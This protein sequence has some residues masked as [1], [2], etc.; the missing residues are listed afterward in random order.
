MTSLAA[1]DIKAIFIQLMETM[2]Q[3]RDR[4]TKL[5]AALGD[6]DLGITMTKGFT[7]AATALDEETSSDIGRL[8][9]RAGMTIAS[10]APSTMGTLIASGFMKAGKELKGAE[11]ISLEGILTLFA[12]FVNGIRERGKAE[13]GDKTIID[14]L[15]PAVDALHRAVDDNTSLQEALGMAHNAALEGAEA[16]RNMAA[17]HGRPSYY[18]DQSV[19]KEDPGSIVGVLI[20]KVFA[21][22]A[23]S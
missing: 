21:E 15:V 2:E 16:T 17:K 3:N 20:M 6:G 22:Y 18:G 7:E 23:T 4:L 10:H 14:S 19:G 5:D 12:S 11:T 13:P 9:M 8:V 1:S